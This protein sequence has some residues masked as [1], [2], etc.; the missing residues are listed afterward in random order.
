ML[1]TELYT[2]LIS[3]YGYIGEG[4]CT[5][6]CLG[7]PKGSFYGAFRIFTEMSGIK[8]LKDSIAC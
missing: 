3:K 8:E 2:P 6:R 4:M 1:G 5:L 7:E